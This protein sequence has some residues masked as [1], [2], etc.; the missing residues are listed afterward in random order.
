MLREKDN[1]K[2]NLNGT[3]SGG[4]GC[5]RLAQERTTGGF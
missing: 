5:I 3:G 2:I 1:I 4:V